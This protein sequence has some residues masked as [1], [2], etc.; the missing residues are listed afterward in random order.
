MFSLL[1]IEDELDYRDSLI[2]LIGQDCN[3]SSAE[4]FCE[5]SA[6]I[7]VSNPFD[8]ILLDKHLPDSEGVELIPLIRQKSVDTIIFVHSAYNQNPPLSIDDP[9]IISLDKLGNITDLKR[10]IFDYI[11]RLNG[12][13]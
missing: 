12:K 9:R 5:A 11:K 3:V 4:S 6:L 13:V 2:E 10:N 8:A 1:I 7:N